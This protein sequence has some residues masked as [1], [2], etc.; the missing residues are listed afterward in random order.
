M[1]MGMVLAYKLKDILAKYRS[2]HQP[3]S[4]REEKVTKN[5]MYVGN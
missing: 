1:L 2:R 3:V 4:E 5:P